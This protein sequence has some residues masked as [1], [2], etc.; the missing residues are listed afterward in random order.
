MTQ[1]NRLRLSALAS[2]WFARRGGSVRNARVR[3]RLGVEALEERQLLTV[4]L[5]DTLSS[6]LNPALVGQ[7]VTFT[8]IVASTDSNTPTGS[9]TFSIDGQNQD[10]VDLT[11]VEGQEEATF[12]TSTLTQGTHTVAAAYSGD[13]NFAPMTSNTV[14]EHVNSATATTDTTTTLSP[15]DN[16]ATVGQVVTFTAVVDA[17][18]NGTPTGTV[19]FDID[20]QAQDPVDL[21]V[22]DGLDV[23]TFATSSLTQGTHTVSADYNGDDTFDVSSSDALDE[24]INAATTTTLTTSGSP[25][26]VGDNVTFT[27]VVAT[28]GTGTPG[29]R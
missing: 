10:P 28:T 6:S 23:A 19:T 14:L 12:M 25:A 13:D 9:V 29:E 4:S 24:Q 27:A 2:S 17:G 21:Q 20:G 18:G 26:T 1:R 8:A 22:V 7:G 11:D 3:S 16:P 5:T 15:S